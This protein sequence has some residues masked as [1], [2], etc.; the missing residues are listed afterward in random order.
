MQNSSGR[1]VALT[2]GHDRYA[3][4]RVRAGAVLASMQ[5]DGWKVTRITTQSSMWPV[6][7][8]ICLIV[9]RP[10]VTFLQ[11]VAPPT[12]FSMIV[13]L[14]SRRLV[15]EC[16]DAIQLGYESNSI[17]AQKTSGKLGALL[18]LCDRVIVSNAVLRNDF[19]KLG[20]RDL[21]VFPGPAPSVAA[22]SQEIRDGVLWLGSPS[23]VDNVRQIVY[24]A[25]KL[26]DDRIRLTVVGSDQVSNTAQVTENPWSEDLQAASLARARVGLAPQRQDPWSK[27]K[28]FYKVLEYLAASVVPVVPAQP[29]IFTLLGDEIDIVAVIATDDTPCSWAAAI[30]RALAVDV[31]EEW[32]AA[33]DRV[34]SRWSAERLGQVLLK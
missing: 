34:F 29:A 17:D 13:R 21:V 11:K 8:F 22:L 25:M 30:E 16:D 32:L 19:H 26:L 1:I 24:P 31:G 14:L 4:S 3:S 6:R 18:P 28:A 12:L 20:A 9:L 2:L 5:Q 27:R 23:T 15:F 10:P 7:L 33:R